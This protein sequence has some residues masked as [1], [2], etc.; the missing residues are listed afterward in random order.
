MNNSSWISLN[1]I[2]LEAIGGGAVFR[3]QAKYPYERIVD[4]ML[5]DFPHAPSGHALIVATGYK[6]GHILIALPAE[7]KD[8]K[9]HGVSVVWLRDNWKKWIYEIGP[10][11]VFYK[12]RYTVNQNWT[13][14]T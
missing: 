8:Q 11:M 9:S 3:C 7:A 4:F 5:I 12:R 6:S 14:K 13:P 1:G 2:K 10:E